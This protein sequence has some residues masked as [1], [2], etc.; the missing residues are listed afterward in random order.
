M[1]AELREADDQLV[2]MGWALPSSPDGKGKIIMAFFLKVQLW[3]W[4]LEKVTETVF[5]LSFFFI[6]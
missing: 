1:V 4:K 3:S 2:H 6:L 5:I